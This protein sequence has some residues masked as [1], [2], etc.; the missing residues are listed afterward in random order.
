[1]RSRT[2]T[3]EHCPSLSAFYDNVNAIHARM[4]HDD[5]EPSQSTFGFRAGERA[6]QLL[7]DAPRI[8]VAHDPDLDDY[9]VVISVV[10]LR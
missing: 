6:A 10:T 3:I 9:A 4:R 2:Y 8:E 1:M 7:A 5:I